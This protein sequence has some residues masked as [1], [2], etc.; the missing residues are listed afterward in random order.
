MLATYIAVELAVCVCVSDTLPQVQLPAGI[1]QLEGPAVFLWP[2]AHSCLS[3]R[4]HHHTYMSL[5]DMYYINRHNTINYGI[6][7]ILNIS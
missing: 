1:I 6:M 7:P 2:M 4:S 5:R 3:S